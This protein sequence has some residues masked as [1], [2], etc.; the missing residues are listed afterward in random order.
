MVV[1]ISD[2]AAEALTSGGGEAALGMES[3]LRC[4]LGD[5]DAD[6]PAWPY[7]SFLRGTETP[8]DV[9]IEL[10]VP[11]SL[12]TEFEAEAARQDVTLDQLAEHAAF[13][14]AAEIEAGRVTE[15][16]LDGPEA[17]ERG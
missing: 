7:P 5:R 4:Y 11:V 15:R 10:A 1:A 17:E 12:W 9:R 3:A 8:G 6:R 2:L 13:Y 14:L 16:I